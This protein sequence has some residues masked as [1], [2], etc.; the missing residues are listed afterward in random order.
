MFGYYRDF[1]Y[2]CSEADAISLFS[3]PG[4]SGNRGRQGLGDPG[5]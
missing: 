2:P 3:R 1:Q 5:A 4:I